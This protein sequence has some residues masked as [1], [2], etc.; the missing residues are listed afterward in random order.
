MTEQSNFLQGFGFTAIVIAFLGRLH[1][2]GIVLAALFIGYVNGGATW[3]Q[4][5]L[6]E[7]DSIAGYVGSDCAVQRGPQPFWSATELS[8]LE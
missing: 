6:K 1:P 8:G 4:A 3:V 5:N 7:D 2:V